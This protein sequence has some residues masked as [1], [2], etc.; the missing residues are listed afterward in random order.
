[1]YR[2]TECWMFN[3]EHCQVLDKNH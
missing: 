2:L 1:M 3:W